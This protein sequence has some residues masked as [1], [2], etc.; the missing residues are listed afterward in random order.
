MSKSSLAKRGLAHPRP[1]TSRTHL[2]DV[3]QTP[4]SFN[5]K[6]VSAITERFLARCPTAERKSRPCGSCQKSSRK[7]MPFCILAG[8]CLAPLRSRASS[9]NR[10]QT[11][12]A[13]AHRAKRLPRSAS[14]ASPSQR[15]KDWSCQPSSA[16]CNTSKVRYASAS[17]VKHEG[18]LPSTHDGTTARFHLARHGNGS[19]VGVASSLS[20]LVQAKA[21]PPRG[22]SQTQPF[23]SKHLAQG[24]A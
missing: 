12:I 15:L 20:L 19:C 7:S 6:S 1:F 23:A 17:H 5:M 14:V 9:I 13:W 10:I 8:R 21:L 22:R 18:Y 16:F 4:R 2:I 3:I 24:G 11:Y